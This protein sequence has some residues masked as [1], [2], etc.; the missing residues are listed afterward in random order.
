MRTILLLIPLLPAVAFADDVLT[1]VDDALKRH[2]GRRVAL[3]ASPLCDASDMPGAEH[4]GFLCEPSER[5]SAWTLDGLRADGGQKVQ[6][7]LEV[8]RFRSED[9]AAQAWRE[10]LGR[11]GGREPT[12]IGDG[13][14]SW[15]FLDVIDRGDSLVALEYGCHISL[16]HVKALAAMRAAL[17]DDATPIS[18]TSA[19]AIAGQHSGWSI[20]VGRDGKQVAVEPSARPRRF[21]RVRGVATDDV[22]WLREFA[23]AGSQKVGKLAPDARCIPVVA[24]GGDGGWW[25][26]ARSGLRGWAW[27]RYLEAEPD[28]ACDA[29]A[30]R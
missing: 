20:L 4:R 13:A 14:I 9:A 19:V 11:F 24:T 6:A 15:C 27:G 3:E 7:R 12:F 29:D 17:L 25:R 2:G 23:K 1:R 10:A 26:L 8:R 5:V 21:A 28:G 16:R 30:G 18:G 22:L